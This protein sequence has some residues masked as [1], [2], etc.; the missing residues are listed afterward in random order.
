MRAPG[1]WEWKREWKQ[2]ALR[3]SLGSGLL[4]AVIGLSPS[5]HAGQ[6]DGVTWFSGVASVALAAWSTPAP[7]NDDVGVGLSPNV[8]PI[9]QKDYTAIGPVDIV[10]DVIDSGGVTEYL[11]TEGVQNNT[12]LDWNSYHIE[13]GF[14]VGAGFSPSLPGDG[15]DF[16]APD[17]LSDVS[18]NP[19]P[20]FFPTHV[21]TEDDILA[22]GG[23]M[24]SP[25]FAGN[26]IFHV[27]VPDGIS[28]F[29]IRQSPIAVPEPSVV[30]LLGMGLLGLGRRGRR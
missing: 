21:V 19:L 2:K 26:F 9:L 13:L 28:Q 12:G 30:V 17:F 4:A 18:F 27:D 11:V 10:I 14:G 8:L 23:I 22:S 3:R 24:P 6:I 29:T 25:S 16:D 20:G 1:K 7:N 15:L 5:A